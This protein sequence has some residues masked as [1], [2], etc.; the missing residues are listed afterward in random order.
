MEPTPK[1]STSSIVVA[2][3]IWE[4]Q[5]CCH[6]CTLLVTKSNYTGND[7][8]RACAR[9]HVEGDAAVHIATHVMD[10]PRAGYHNQNLLEVAV[11]VFAAITTLTLSITTG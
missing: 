11:G 2:R 7:V 4:A 10:R 1:I 3:P 5:P 6:F 9:T 8:A